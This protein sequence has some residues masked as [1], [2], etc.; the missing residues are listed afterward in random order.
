MFLQLVFLFCPGTAGIPSWCLQNLLSPASPNKNHRESSSQ[1]VRYDNRCLSGRNSRYELSPRNFITHFLHVHVGMKDIYI[2]IYVDSWVTCCP[3]SEINV[4]SQAHFL[5]A[6]SQL[7]NILKCKVEARG[8]NFLKNV[9]KVSLTST[10]NQLTSSRFET[11][12]SPQNW[13]AGLRC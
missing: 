6:L 11:W 4:A 9:L 3:T 1:V 13:Q 2:Y 8:H 7:W 12:F 10:E 5:L